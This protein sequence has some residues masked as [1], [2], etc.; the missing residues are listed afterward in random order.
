MYKR[1]LIVLAI[2]FVGCKDAATT[3]NKHFKIPDYYHTGFDSV[4]ILEY[5]DGRPPYVNFCYPKNASAIDWDTSK[6]ETITIPY[7][8]PCGTDH[9]VGIYNIDS[10]I[11]Y[12]EK[13]GN[14]YFNMKVKV[15]SDTKESGTVYL[16]PKGTPKYKAK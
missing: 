6:F 12:W 1:L 4:Q 2:A 13:S 3:S 16:I 7:D 8:P 11:D 10:C 5:T 14:Y 9:F 15:I